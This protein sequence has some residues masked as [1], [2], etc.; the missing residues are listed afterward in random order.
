MPESVG[1]EI[2]VVEEIDLDVRAME[3]RI[4]H[5]TPENTLKGDSGASQN[6]EVDTY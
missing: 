3:Q 2:V 1:A 5:G 6:T 4:A